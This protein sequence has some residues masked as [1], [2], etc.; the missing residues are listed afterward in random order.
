MTTPDRPAGTAGDCDSCQY[1]DAM[2]CTYAGNAH[3][4]A[5]IVRLRDAHAP[6]CPNPRGGDPGRQT[7]HDG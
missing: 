1:L 5:A 3:Q 7:D 4:V 2:A 6:T